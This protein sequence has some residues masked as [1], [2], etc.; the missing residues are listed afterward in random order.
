MLF[1]TLHLYVCTGRL[2]LVYPLIQ[3]DFFCLWAYTGRLFHLYLPIQ[4]GFLVYAIKKE[5]LFTSPLSYSVKVSINSS[6][7]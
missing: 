4:V 5:R 7:S 6:N 1:F 2:F 3:V